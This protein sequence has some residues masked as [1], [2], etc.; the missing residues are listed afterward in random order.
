MQ[1]WPLILSAYQYKIEYRQSNKNAKADAMSQ[2]PVGEAVPE[3]DG[4]MFLCSFLEEIPIE[5]RDIH[6]TTK[7]DSTLSLASN[8]TTEGC[9]RCL[10]QP[11]H[12]IFQSKELFVS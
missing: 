3:C 10:D 5:A 1:T 9:P 12:V 2:L 8:Y 11:Q 6:D 4:G 7:V